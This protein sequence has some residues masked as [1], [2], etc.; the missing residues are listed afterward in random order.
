MSRRTP[1]GHPAGVDRLNSAELK[2]E[3]PASRSDRNVAKGASRPERKLTWC[4]T[5]GALRPTDSRISKY[6]PPSSEVWTCVEPP[7]RNSP[8]P[9]SNATHSTEPPS[10]TYTARTKPPTIVGPTPRTPSARPTNGRFGLPGYS[11]TTG[12]IPP[13]DRVLHYRFRTRVQRC[14][15][16]QFCVESRFPLPNRFDH[17]RSS[18]S[19]KKARNGVGIRQSDEEP[20]TLGTAAS[21]CSER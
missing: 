2:V 13:P 10:N 9:T 17:V 8:F 11:P 5:T 19:V 20:K 7:S 12:K 15:T 21:R 1:R 18:F 3:P 6:R 16:R 14:E 4:D